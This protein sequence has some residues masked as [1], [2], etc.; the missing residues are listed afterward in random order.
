MTPR[1][2]E[3]RQE[4]IT[5]IIGETIV[6]GVVFLIAFGA[7][8]LFDIPVDWRTPI[9]LAIATICIVVQVGLGTHGVMT[10][11]QMNTE[12]ALSKMGVSDEDLYDE[13]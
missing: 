13:G 10:M 8:I 7:M 11:I 2:R 9:T 5:R 1:V 6:F 3:I 4:A 12:F